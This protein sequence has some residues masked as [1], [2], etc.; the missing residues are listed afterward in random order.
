[1]LWWTAA[2]KRV[3]VVRSTCLEMC[4]HPLNCKI[5]KMLLTTASQ[6]MQVWVIVY[7]DELGLEATGIHCLW[8][9]NGDSQS[10]T[11]VSFAEHAD[12]ER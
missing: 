9:C 3:C 7:S 2:Q 6:H 4:L 11:V 1:M 8:K 12:A 5:C 10:N